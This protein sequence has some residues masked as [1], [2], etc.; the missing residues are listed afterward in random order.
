MEVEDKEENGRDLEGGEHHS[1]FS[2]T[3]D[4]FYR[5]LR[6]HLKG[7]VPSVLVPSTAVRGVG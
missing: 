5:Q 6:L 3:V 2:S 1:L 4:H 7:N